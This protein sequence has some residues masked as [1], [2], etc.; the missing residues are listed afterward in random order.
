MSKVTKKTQYF[1]EGQQVLRAGKSFAAELG[2]SET[3]LR[4]WTLENPQFPLPVHTETHGNNIVRYYPYF[5][6]MKII[7][8]KLEDYKVNRA[9]GIGRPSKVKVS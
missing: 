1:I 9:K 7:M 4:T 3:V 2:V 5:S 8:E 6:A